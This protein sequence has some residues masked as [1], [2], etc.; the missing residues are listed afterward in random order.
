MSL[1]IER[2]DFEQLAPASSRAIYFQDGAE[3]RLID[4]VP[5]EESE[6]QWNRKPV[7]AIK[8][9]VN[10]EEKDIPAPA[11]MGAVV[12]N[13]DIIKNEGD[14][15][16]ECLDFVGQTL[17]DHLK[18]TTPKGED[19]KLPGKLNVIRRV[20]KGVE[21]GMI[22]EKKAVYEKSHLVEEGKKFDDA[23]KQY[24]FIPT[25]FDNEMGSPRT[26]KAFLLDTID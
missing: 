2:T 11:L 25:I 3:L 17:H 10:G 5:A 8:L 23:F 16:M 24:D 12:K 6:I 19:I 7:A 26:N 4:F 22:K 14:S 1:T 18:K 13:K 21:K 20:N 15:E 9:E